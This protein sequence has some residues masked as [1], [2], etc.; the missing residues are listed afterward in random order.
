VKLACPFSLRLTRCDWDLVFGCAGS[1][2]DRGSNC[3]GRPPHR[4]SKWSLW[5]D[6]NPVGG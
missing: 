6:R 2:A 4:Q 3:P 1:R 5:D